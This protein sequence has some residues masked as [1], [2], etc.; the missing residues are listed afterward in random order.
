MLYRWLNNG[1]LCRAS[2]QDRLVLGDKDYSDENEAQK[3]F[4]AVEHKRNGGVEFSDSFS[5]DDIDFLLEN[6]DSFSL[7]QKA[8]L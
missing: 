4:R 8:V 3:F 7:Y 5:D 6:S 1:E 2:R